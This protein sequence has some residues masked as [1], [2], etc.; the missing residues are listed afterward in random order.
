[1]YLIKPSIEIR[2]QTDL[3]KQI[4]WAGR[5][6]YKS[7]HLITNNSAEKFV[8]MI[9]RKGHLSV[10]EHG[11]VYLLL[12]WEHYSDRPWCKVKR[13]Y[14]KTFITTNYRDIVENKLENFMHY[15]CEPT[16]YHE[17]RMTVKFITSRS[18]AQEFT[19]HRVFSFSMESQRYCN[20]SKDKFN[21]T[22]TF[23]R[24]YWCEIEPGQYTDIPEWRKETQVFIKM[25]IDAEKAYFDLLDLACVPQEAREVLP[26]ACKTELVMT[27]FI[28][29]WKN[30]CRLRYSENAHPDACKLAKMV[31]DELS[32]Y[33]TNSER[34]ST[35]EHS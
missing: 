27:G 18:I 10:L 9:K 24:P 4:E 5:T 8:D 26:N 15:Q 32:D 7:E 17:R 20:Y 12:P 33:V 31:H 11:T 1:M 29:D 21:K 14:G 6:C 2:K 28:S 23:V 22:V 16:D 30:F 35:V 19:R 13:L 3:F 34:T 25:C